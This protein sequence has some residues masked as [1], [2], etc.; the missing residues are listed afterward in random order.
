MIILAH[1]PIILS[2][3]ILGAH[4][5]R[6]GNHGLMLVFALLPLLMLSRRRWVGIVMPLVLATGALIWLDT[7]AQIAS[8]RARM[9]QDWVR[10]AVILGAVTAITAGSAL[11]F[12]TKRLKN[13]YNQFPETATAS[14]VGFIIT[15]LLLTIVHLK[16]PLTLLL[17]ERFWPTMG[18]VEILALSIYAAFVVEKMLDKTQTARWRRRIW[19]LFS[20]V[21]FAQLI[22]GL[23]G[24]ERFLMT[25]NLHLPVPAMIAA[26]PIYRGH[27]FFMPILFLSTVILVGPAWCSHLCYIGSWDSAASD[28]KRKPQKL[29]PWTARVRW[30]ILAFIIAAAIILRLAGVPSLI[31]TILGLTFGLVGVLVMLLWS[32]KIGVMAH[33]VVYCPIGLVANW[34]GKV[35]PFRVRIN[36][37]CTDCGICRMSCKYNALNMTDI[38]NRKPAIS[39]TLCGDC[40]G[41][42]EHSSLEYRFW[43]YK[44]KAARTVFIVMVVSLHAACLGLARI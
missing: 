30:G 18:W 32:R 8:L 24:V 37:S 4:F 12:L 3:F 26:G 15:G 6:G 34:L 7:I 40:I 25:G 36:D 41:S 42:C 14:A 23:L 20:V 44:A 35:S 33:C 10:M 19:L 22:I 21:F 17:V 31:A 1:I 5:M 2:C 43:N 13:R 11:L 28:V 29:P 16:V 27:N 39:C 9:G 38:K